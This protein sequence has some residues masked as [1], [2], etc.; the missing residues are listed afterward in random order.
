[1][2][3]LRVASFNIQHGRLPSGKVDI[4][5][6]ARACAALESDVLALQE[7]DRWRLRSGF[8]HQARTIARLTGMAHTFSP[9]LRTWWV[10]AYGDALLVRGRL[11]E[12]ELVA[13]PHERG[14]EPRTAIVA[15]VNVKGTRL[16]VAATHLSVAT[17]ES[18]PQLL[19]ALAA[20]ARRPRPWLLLGDLNLWPD[21]VEPVVTRAGLTLVDPSAPTFPA[22]APRARIDHCAVSDLDVGAIETPE[23]PVS[24]HRALVVEVRADPPAKSSTI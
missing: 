5:L 21:R 11:T 20:L 3:P 17:R 13:L 6:T 7:V 8:A 2:G 22:R 1:M 14:H 12:V 10:S 16:S 19:A 15:E 18:E 24:D 4:R 23:L 9:A